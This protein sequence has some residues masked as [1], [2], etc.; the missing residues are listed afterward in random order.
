MY[1]NGKKIIIFL[2]F[3]FGASISE[4]EFISNG[5]RRSVV[6]EGKRSVSDVFRPRP[7]IVFNFQG[8]LY[9]AFLDLSSV[10]GIDG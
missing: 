3:F 8:R 9:F 5:A 6:G 10:R 7:Q 1:L 2:F 4:R